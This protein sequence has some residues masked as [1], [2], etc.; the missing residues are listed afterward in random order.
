MTADRHPEPYYAVAGLFDGDIALV[1][2]A[3]APR[4]HWLIV[5]LPDRLALGYCAKAHR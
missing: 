2:P 1:A 3:W 5:R 4:E